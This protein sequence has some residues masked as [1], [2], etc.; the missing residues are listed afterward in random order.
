MLHMLLIWLCFKCTSQQ[1]VRTICPPS[2]W[3]ANA[4]RMPGIQATFSVLFAL[5]DDSATVS[6]SSPPLSALTRDINKSAKS[7]AGSV[8]NMRLVRSPELRVYRGTSSGIPVDPFPGHTPTPKQN[9][10]GLSVIVHVVKRTAHW[11]FMRRFF[12]SSNSLNEPLNVSL[13][14]GVH[15]AYS[16]LRT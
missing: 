12:C 6:G 10:S 13:F 3:D 8:E 11:K 1:E 16:T 14:H 4:T 2:A 5:K 15:S 9:P 7:A